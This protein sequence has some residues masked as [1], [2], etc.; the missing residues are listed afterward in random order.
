VHKQELLVITKPEQHDIDAAGKRL[1]REALE[2]L[3]WVVNEVEKDYDIDFNVQIFEAQSPTGDWFHVQLKSSADS[4]YSADGSFISQRLSIDHARHY[5][6]EMRDP[7]FL[8]H[9]DVV[10]QK[11][12]WNAP[13]LDRALIAVL[14]KTKAE[15]VIVRITTDHE[16]PKNV[17]KL[18]RDLESIYL[19]LGSRDI[20]SATPQSFEQSLK[21]VPDEEAP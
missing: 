5:A 18:L 2:S 17:N 20:I 9:A 21:H 11:V 1:L 19:V 6:L 14:S 3:K 16:L 4:E 8:I 12:F 10:A 13:Q 15:S 7:V